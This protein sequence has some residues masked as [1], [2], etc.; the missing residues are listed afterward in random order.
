ML[1]LLLLFSGKGM[2]ATRS[3]L[4]PFEDKNQNYWQLASIQGVAVG[5]PGMFVGGAIA[6]RFGSLPAIL[7]ILIGNLIL[8]LIGLGTIGMTQRGE[9]AI[10]NIG[11]FLGL[12]GKFA[13]S[14]IIGLAFLGWYTMQCK[15]GTVII[16]SFFKGGA[17]AQIRIGA[18]L[19]T[20]IALF[21]MGGIR[22]IKWLNVVSLPIL[23]LLLLLFSFNS[24]QIK[25]PLNAPIEF[26]FFGIVAIVSVTLPGVLNLPTFF[27]HSR[28]RS[29][30]FLALTLMTIFVSLF[31]CFS[32]IIGIANAEQVINSNAPAIIILSFT[33]LSL[34]CINTVNIYLA[35]GVLEVLLKRGAESK[36]YAIIGLFGTG[37]FALLQALPAMQFLENVINSSIA[38]IGA[39]LIIRF[40]IKSIVT[41]RP[42]FFDRLI[43]NGCWVI[44]AIFSLLFLAQQP[45]SPNLALLIGIGVSIISLLTIVFFETTIWSFLKSSLKNNSK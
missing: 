1:A 44:G 38:S 42:R 17:E 30:S 10:E 35:S 4:I 45:Q 8:W 43:S 23:L 20:C 29:H 22:F 24:L 39:V 13:F 6:E 28:S 7:S 26:P 15:V 9:N 18:I 5:F 27:R 14:L 12:E 34:F 2:H 16:T 31:Q 37:A 32:V 33:L 40:L 25:T 19:G 36:D 3:S 11:N 21:S 41:H